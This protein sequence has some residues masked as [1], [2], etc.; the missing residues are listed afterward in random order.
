VVFTRAVLPST[1]FGG[2]I[3][4]VCG[5]VAFGLGAVLILSRPDGMEDRGLQSDLD[6]TPWWPEFERDFYAYLR[7]DLKRHVRL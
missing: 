6:P 7:R 3:A 5:L 2:Q 1:A 4:F